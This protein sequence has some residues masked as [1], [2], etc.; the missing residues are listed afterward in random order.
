MASQKHKVPQ[1]HHEIPNEEFIESRNIIATAQNLDLFINNLPYITLILD[2]NRHI[3]YANQK[4]IDFQGLINLQQAIGMLPGDLVKC[5][6]A[7]EGID[8]CGSATACNYCGCFITVQESLLKNKTITGDCRI[9]ALK[10][11]QEIPLE[12]QITSSPITMKN[13]LFVIVSLLDI[14]S[15]K[16][17]E[18]FERVFLHDMVNSIGGMSGLLDI[19]KIPSDDRSSNLLKLLKNSTQNLLNELDLYR[20]LN[21]AELGL[22]KTNTTTINADEFIEEIHSIMACYPTISEDK[23]IILKPRPEKGIVFNSDYN[24]AVKV[25]MNMVKNALEATDAGG[26]V[27]LGYTCTADAITFQVNNAAVMAPS[28]QS[29]IFQR[30][31]S[32]KGNGHGVGAYSMKLFMER[33]LNGSISFASNET[34]GTT[35]YAKFPL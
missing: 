9:T 34:D 6:H 17:K 30:S 27:K 16:Q 15:E 7:H 3:V 29:Q 18:R 22:L 35:F 21:S 2:K 28:A 24:L 23:L 14:S 5:I 31:F 12:L 11:G 32:T 13:K 1:S 20:E 19:L 26:T 33:Y 8:G 25:I 4:M 10:E